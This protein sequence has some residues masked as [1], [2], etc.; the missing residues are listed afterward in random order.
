MTN[1]TAIIIPAWK[2]QSGD[3]AYTNVA[4]A[5]RN[6]GYDVTHYPIV[7]HSSTFAGWAE[8]IQGAI[9]RATKPVTVCAY[10]LGA[11]V[12]LA[13]AATVPIENLIVC[14]P[15]GYFKEY[16]ALVP[17]G[18][19]RWMGDAR[20]IEFNGL[21][22]AFVLDGPLVG[23][24][25]IIL[26]EGEFVARPAYRMWINDLTAATN[27]PLICLPHEPYGSIS[28]GYQKAVV[29]TIKTL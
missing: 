1:H 24:G 9:T 7:W 22:A 27:W 3:A 11:M 28:P 18:E 2:Q 8:A 12:A 26:D 23:R 6:A 17:P 10:G 13:A 20:K 16:F 5:L 14:S 21:S 4:A 29:T 19:Q 15:C 25:H